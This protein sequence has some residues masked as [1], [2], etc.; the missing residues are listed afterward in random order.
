MPN[1]PSSITIDSPD[2]AD[3]MLIFD[4]TPARS[5]NRWKPRLTTM[6]EVLLSMS[7]DLE[8]GAYVITDNEDGWFQRAGF[9]IERRIS[10]QAASRSLRGSH[11]SV[12]LPPANSDPMDIHMKRRRL[13]FEAWWLQVERPVIVDLTT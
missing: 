5:Q 4:A 9:P 1:M 13:R 3:G 2:K 12:K 10:R 8:H 7:R 11:L 6:L